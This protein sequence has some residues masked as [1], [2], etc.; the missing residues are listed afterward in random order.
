MVIF[1]KYK[2]VNQR[3]KV[4]EVGFYKCNFVGTILTFTGN[5]SRT[6]INERVRGN[7]SRTIR[8]QTRQEEIKVADRKKAERG[9]PNE[10]FGFGNGSRS[11]RSGTKIGNES[12]SKRNASNTERNEEEPN[13][14][15]LVQKRKM[16]LHFQ[17]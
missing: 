12:S 17:A 5:E 7:E 3:S 16:P 4:A 10:N 1:F 9:S 6:R 2:T 8:N 11:R 15:T 13:I 14:L